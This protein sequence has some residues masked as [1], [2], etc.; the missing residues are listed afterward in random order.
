MKHY[1]VGK[2]NPNFKYNISKKLLI[3][4]YLKENKSINEIAK[5]FNCSIG[6]IRRSFKIFNIKARKMS[7]ACKVGNTGKYTRTDFHKKILRNI[8]LKRFKNTKEIKKYSK[9]FKGKNNPNWRGGL[10]IT[11]YK[12]FTNNIREYIR[13]RD[14]YRCKNCNITEK[15]HL[16]I[17]KLK[18]SVH[19]IDYDKKNS[20]E[21]NLITLCKQCHSRTNFNRKKWERSLR[22]LLVL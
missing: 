19:H 1:N 14:D 15:E 5:Y 12:N 9:M 7:R 21:S 13:K 11:K 6:P 8:T 20:S 4:K 16:K 18:L 22:A 3:K 2:N 17:L 10:S